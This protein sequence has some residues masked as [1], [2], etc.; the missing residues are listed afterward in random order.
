MSELIIID[1]RYCGPP[2][3]G[4]GGY[5]GGVLAGRIG[6]AVEANF[7]R[8]VP[9]DR[10]LQ[11]DREGDGA[12]RLYDQGNL[13]VEAAPS[14]VTLAVPEAP[15][16]QEAEAA[17]RR[18]LG[19]RVHTPFVRC[20]GCGI[21]RG[22]GYGLRIFAGPT[23]RENLY[24]APWLPESTF[25][26]DD[27]RV[28]PEFVW[29]SLDCSAGFALMGHELRLYVTARLAVDIRERPRAGVPHVVT[30][31]VVGRGERKNVCGTALFGADA[32]LLALARSLWIDLRA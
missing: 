11:L 18:F 22:A 7:R 15:T 28:R 12:L 3:A 26:D 32:R 27:G 31:W 29:A 16:L 6:G 25:A 23:D 1:H 8:P 10:E 30:A 24:A 14:T 17:S 19:R 9:L 13:L 21:E 2:D 20:F 4:N 5:V